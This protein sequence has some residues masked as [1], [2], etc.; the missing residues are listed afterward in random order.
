MNINNLQLLREMFFP[1]HCALC[2]SPLLTAEEAQN[3]IC[4][5]CAQ[6]FAVEDVPRCALCGKPLIS[7]KRLCM[8]CRKMTAEDAPD[9]DTPQGDAPQKDAVG[10]AFDSAFVI[11]PYMGK[12]RE[13]LKA[14]KFGRRKTLARFFA[15]KVLNARSM[16][17]VGDDAVWVPVPPRKG[18]IKESGWEQ[19]EELAKALER[20]TSGGDG[21]KKIIVER[22]LERLP[23]RSQ[24]ELDKEN[25]RHNLKGKIKCTKP[26]AKNIVIF[27][28]VFT[29][30]ST[31]S[32]CAEEL[33]ANGAEQVRGLC[34]FYD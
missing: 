6:K 11:F 24:K 1:A 32:V 7:E 10:F 9:K 4:A 15:E 26:A 13:L 23:S 16:M 2:A 14:Y 3:G 21:A 30:G 18:K 27:D 17:S 29:T 5:A 28:D 22:C 34:L 12:Y 33:K 19:V 25:R 20:L 31:L 8:S